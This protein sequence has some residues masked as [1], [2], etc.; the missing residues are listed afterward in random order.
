MFVFFA[1]DNGGA[2]ANASNNGPLRD[3]KANVYERGIG[4]PVLLRWPAKLPQD[5]TIAD[6]V[7]CMDLRPTAVAAVLV[8]CERRPDGRS[9][10]LLETGEQSGQ[11]G[12]V[13]LGRSKMR[14][15]FAA[16][17][18][19]WRQSGCPECRERGCLLGAGRSHQIAYVH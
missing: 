5:R 3:F 8:G 13:R 15:E 14:R 12:T 11:G 4:V 10:W 2:R 17:L 9:E 18:Q 19:R 7:I 1:S 16:G 6:P